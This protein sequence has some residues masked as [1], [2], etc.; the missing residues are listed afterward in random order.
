MAVTKVYVLGPGKRAAT[1][2]P[3]EPADP[4]LRWHAAARAAH[5]EPHHFKWYDGEVFAVDWQAPGMLMSVRANL[6]PELGRGRPEPHAFAQWGPEG[7]V[8]FDAR[9]SALCAAKRRSLMSA[10]PLRTTVQA[11]REQVDQMRFLIWG[12]LVDDLTPAQWRRVT[13]WR[14][15]EQYDRIAFWSETDG[16]LIAGV[17][18]NP[19]AP[20]TIGIVSAIRW[21]PNAEPAVMNFVAAR[22]RLRLRGRVAANLGGQAAVDKPIYQWLFDD[23]RRVTKADEYGRMYGAR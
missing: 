18:R 2:V 8:V 1:T 5:I 17:A 19:T 10:A 9:F 12:T 21:I 20:S 23:Y 13:R 14:K 6:L 7:R 15:H 22:M 3:F 16:S 11:A 4:L